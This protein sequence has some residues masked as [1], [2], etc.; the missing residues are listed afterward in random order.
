MYGFWHVFLACIPSQNWFFYGSLPCKIPRLFLG[1]IT[2]FIVVLLSFFNVFAQNWIFYSFFT[3][4]RINLSHHQIDFVNVVFLGN[5]YCY[6][7]AKLNF[8]Y[9]LLWITPLLLLRKVD[10]FTAVFLA[11]DLIYPITKLISYCSFSWKN[12]LLFMCKLFLCSLPCLSLPCVS[13]LLFSR[14]IEFFAVVFLAKD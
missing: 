12:L 2:F 7:C 8:H 11:K 3:C 14:K 13:L 10:F 5:I 1:K 4:K 9:S 6:F